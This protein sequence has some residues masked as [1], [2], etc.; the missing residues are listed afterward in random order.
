MTIEVTLD[1]ATNN[2]PNLIGEMTYISYKY[3]RERSP[4]I[5]PEQWRCVFDNTEAME[6]RY[7]REITREE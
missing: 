3:N 5:T 4:N 2:Y 7:Q 1:E 6:E